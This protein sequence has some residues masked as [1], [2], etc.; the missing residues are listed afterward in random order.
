MNLKS[1]PCLAILVAWCS[2][3][4]AQAADSP[5]A[6]S[7]ANVLTGWVAN[8]ATGNL[9]RGAAVQLPG[10]GRSELTDDTGR[11]TFRGLPA[12][13]YEIVASYAGLDA[14][15]DRIAVPPGGTV[16]RNFDL[17]SGV[18]QLGTFTVSGQREGAAAAITSQRNADNVKNVVAMDS[19]PGG[20]GTKS[21]GN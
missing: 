6:A 12:G 1:L 13:E 5:S 2:L 17:T 20:A 21:E 18:Y 14:V 4:A 16:R 7:N 15:R 11:Y 10:L 3:T 19:Q 8:A 9:L